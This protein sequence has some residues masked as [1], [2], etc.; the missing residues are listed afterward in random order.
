MYSMRKLLLIVPGLLMLLAVM[1][2]TQASAECKETCHD[3]GVGSFISDPNTTYF[4]CFVGGSYAILPAPTNPLLACDGRHNPEAACPNSV[5]YYDPVGCSL[6]LGEEPLKQC[7]ATAFTR[8]FKQ[9]F[10][11]CS[12]STDPPPSVNCTPSTDPA[13]PG[14]QVTKYECADCEG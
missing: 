10:G 5:F 2:P 9:G 13:D 12:W 14:L 3:I 7:N 4:C 11:V 8:T 1:P 6:G